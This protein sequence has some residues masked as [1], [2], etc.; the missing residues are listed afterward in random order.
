MVRRQAFVHAAPAT[1][2]RRSAGHRRTWT[3][4]VEK[5]EQKPGRTYRAGARQTIWVG[6]E[7]TPTAIA[8][9]PQARYL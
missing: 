3:L 8:K 7:S 1:R 4:R 6:W 2:P 9:K 5:V